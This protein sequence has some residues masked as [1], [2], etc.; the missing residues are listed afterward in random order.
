[1]KRK[2][3]CICLSICLACLSMAFLETVVRPG[4]VL[5]SAGKLA[6]FLGTVWYFGGARGLVR[7]EGLG[8]ALALGAG[9]FGVI[10]GAFFL[11]RPWLDLG[12]L[13]SGLQ[14]KEGICRENF[15]WAALYISLI[16]SGLEELLFRGVGYLRLR[17]CAGEGFAMVFSAAAFA[18]YHIAILEGWFYWWVRLLCLLGLFVGGLIFNW[19]DRRGSIL[20][21]WIAHAAANLAINAIGAYM[22]GII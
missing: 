3:F 4:Y 16:N 17:S 1:M 8:A 13:A 11:F 2:A 14:A 6:L 20:P 12:T 18:A 7:R 21:G 5:K 9:I 22:F 19:L 10:L 15:L